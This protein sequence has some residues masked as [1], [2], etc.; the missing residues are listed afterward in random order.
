MEWITNVF[1]GVENLL[2]N[3]VCERIHQTVGN[4]LWSLREKV[5]LQYK[6]QPIF[7]PVKRIT[8]MSAGGLV[9]MVA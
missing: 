3:A 1:K 8:G 6:C 5:M 9:F 4:V 2:S 7:S